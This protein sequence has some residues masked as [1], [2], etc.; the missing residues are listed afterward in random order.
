MVRPIAPSARPARLE[1]HLLDT[2]VIVEPFKVAQS[3]HRAGD[4]NDGW[5]ARSVRRDGVVGLAQG[6]DLQETGEA[7]ATG[8]VRLQHIDALACSIRRESSV[9]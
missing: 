6:A 8:G 1:Q 5:R 2:D 7:A 3:R 4:G 9:S